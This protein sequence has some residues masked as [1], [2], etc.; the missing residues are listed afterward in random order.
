MGGANWS[1]NQIE[2]K[3]ISNGVGSDNAVVEARVE[4]AFRLAKQNGDWHV[5]E[6]R[7]GDRQWESLDLVEIAV[8]HEKERRTTGLL[9]RIADGLQAYQREK[10]QYPASGEISALLDYLAPRY[11]GDPIRFD[12]WGTQFSYQGT[13]TTYRLSSAGA[14]RKNGTKDDLTIENGVLKA[15][16]N[17]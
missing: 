14:D 11:L 12:W 15:Q 3:S 7:L 8:K 16:N 5:A 4:T 9:Q 13:A 17:E 6:I 10:G 1:S 2:L